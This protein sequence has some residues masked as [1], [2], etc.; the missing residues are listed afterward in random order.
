MKPLVRLIDLGRASFADGLLAQ[1]RCFDAIIES[2]LHATTKPNSTS[3]KHHPNSLIL[4]EHEPVYTIGI[5]SKQ[6]TA[7]LEEKLRK[8]GADFVRT[9][10]GGLI[11]FHGPGQLVAYPILYLGDFD[12]DR[13]SI[14]W[15]VH[16]IEATVISMCQTILET[17]GSK[18]PLPLISTICEYPGVWIEK[19]RKVAAIGV[20]ASRYVTLHGV[21]IN[22]NV[23]LD[24]YKHIV[25][26]GIE[27]KEVT[28]LSKELSLDFSVAE[29]KS[30]FLNSFNESF[31]CSTIQIKT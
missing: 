8:H 16:Q 20:H 22:C 29:A 17:K 12:G 14:K 26:C 24:W 4:V 13:R 1:R 19:E 2:S 30:F 6:Y 9:N 18:A 21:A 7:A 25:P 3:I 31:K 15:Y 27:G 28:S 23:D 10:R 11:T 5:R